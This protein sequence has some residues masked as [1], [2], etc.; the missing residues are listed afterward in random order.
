MQK[1]EAIR[2]YDKFWENNP[3]HS[4]HPSV[5]MR[6][7]FIINTL[8]TESFESLLDAGCGDGFLLN[9]I[10]KNY[11]GKILYGIDISNL[12]IDK[13]K[14]LFKDIEFVAADISGQDLNINKSFDVITCSEVIEHLENWQNAIKNIYLLLKKNGILILT[15]QSGKRYKS[16]LNLGHIQHYEL[17]DLTNELVKNGFE[18]LTAYKKGFPFYNLQKIM[19]EKIESTAND[20]QRGP[21]GTSKIAKI[22]F[23]ITYILFVITPRTKKLGPQI[24]IKALKK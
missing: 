5:R 19:F 7:K 18:I 6:N 17:S 3:S 11:I 14:I 23:F 22:I 4:F 13:N 16:D 21:K 8:K 20:F 9:I 2:D 1:T 15:T 24:F 10:N 12:I